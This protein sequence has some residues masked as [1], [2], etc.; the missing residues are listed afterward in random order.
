MILDIRNEEQYHLEAIQYAH[1]GFVEVY[2]D[3]TIV[4]KNGEGSIEIPMADVNHLSKALS[5]LLE[6]VDG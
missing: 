3:S 6:I 4:I 5:K 2:S 1:N